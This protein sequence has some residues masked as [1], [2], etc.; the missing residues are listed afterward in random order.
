MSIRTTPIL[1]ALIIL[2]GAWLRLPRPQD[3]SFIGN[4]EGY[5]GVYVDRLSELGLGGWPQ[6]IAE[7][8]EKER[9]GGETI[10]PPT[11]I[12]YLGTAYLVRQVTGGLSLDVLRGVSCAA[13]IL[14]L[15]VGAAFVWRM[16]GPVLALGVT[17]LLA[18][19]PLLI[20]LSHRALI[21]GFFA[22]TALVT[23]W[24]LWESLRAP[25]RRA[26]LLLYGAGLAAMVMTKENAAF[27]FAALVAIIGLN[28]WL[29]IGRVTPAL[30]V[31]TFAAPALGALMLVMSAGGPSPLIETYRLNVTK[32]V[33][34][35][36][37]LE[38]GDGPWHRYLLDFLLV[39]P[40][41][42]V[43][44]IAALGGTAWKDPAKRHLAAFLLISGALMV[45]VRYGMNMRYGAMWAVPLCWLA[46][47]LLAT[48]AARL[49]G[50]WQPSLLAAVVAFVCVVELQGY[51]RLFYD[52]T[53]YDPVAG[54]LAMPLQMWKP[55]R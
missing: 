53:I 28:R 32:S 47:N 27:A 22:L 10:L 18:C 23:L 36:Y 16:S 49:P 39:S 25:E 34:L 13:G 11:R 2:F 20:H 41:V 51:R 26:W 55:F 6:V 48:L 43:L 24:G 8:I 5:Y 14:T 45:Q 31:V 40:V 52:G 21:D 33:G 37:A 42:T 35:Q 7:Y 29:Q 12:L 4:D 17:A 19:F 50:R 54:P 9:K 30:L 46:F 3:S 15:V 1:L 44:A 38:T